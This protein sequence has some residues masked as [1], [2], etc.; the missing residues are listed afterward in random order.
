MATRAPGERRTR[1]KRGSCRAR[2]RAPGGG[3][4]PSRDRFSKIRPRTQDRGRIRVQPNWIVCALI[5]GLRSKRL[6]LEM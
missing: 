3:A 5:P 2:Q 6:P 4:G 1:M